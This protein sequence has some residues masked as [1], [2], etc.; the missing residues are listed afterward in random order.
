[1]EKEQKVT[2]EPKVP[3]SATYITSD[4]ILGHDKPGP[5][6]LNVNEK[7]FTVKPLTSYRGRKTGGFIVTQ[8]EPRGVM[9]STRNSQEAADIINEYAGLE[10]SR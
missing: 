2:N 10:I 8:T 7:T 4:D 3:E 5:L 1:M 6:V 9:A